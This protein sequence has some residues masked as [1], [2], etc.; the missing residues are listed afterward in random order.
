MARQNRV[1]QE[2]DFLIHGELRGQRT[3]VVP[4]GT[5]D[6][7]LIPE[8]HRTFQE[9]RALL[10]FHD[11]QGHSFLRILHL[12]YVGEPDPP[13]EDREVVRVILAGGSRVP[14][15]GKKEVPPALAS[16]YNFLAKQGYEVWYVPFEL[17]GPEGPV[18]L[19]TPK[20]AFPLWK[21]KV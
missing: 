4:R 2:H 18:A 8:L 20:G 21:P 3:F 6:Y 5:G 19:W 9:G 11:P 10:Y 14:Y 7:R 13:W 1:R 15:R 17:W 12:D 16:L